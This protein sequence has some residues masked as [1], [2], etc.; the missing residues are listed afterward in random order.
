MNGA[1]ATSCDR[2]SLR[3]CGER[4]P[5]RGSRPG[6]LA[7]LQPRLCVSVCPCA[8][9][10]RGDD[11]SGVGSTCTGNNKAVYKAGC[12]VSGKQVRVRFPGPATL[13]AAAPAPD[14]QGEEQ[15]HSWEGPTIDRNW[16]CPSGA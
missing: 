16:P 4:V 11:G 9:S 12:K 13:G 10:P 7:Q 5:R 8:A 15:G 14:G 6:S 1:E 2:K 3:H